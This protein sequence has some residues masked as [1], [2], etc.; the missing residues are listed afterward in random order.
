M[1]DTSLRAIDALD[2][3]LWQATTEIR[4][5]VLL[6]GGGVDS[7]LLAAMWTKQGHKFRA[8]TVGRNADLRCVPAHDL[9][10]YPCNSD[11]EW[12]AKVANELGLDWTPIALSERDALRQGLI[13]QPAADRVRWLMTQMDR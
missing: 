11:L 8:V 12:S 13:R 4:A 3:A 2:A 9:L 1:N 10:P 5:D 7:A 6:L